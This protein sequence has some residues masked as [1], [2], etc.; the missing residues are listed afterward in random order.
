MS[1]LSAILDTLIVRFRVLWSRGRSSEEGE[2]EF[3]FMPGNQY[4]FLLTESDPI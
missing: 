3:L 1:F 2:K 4:N